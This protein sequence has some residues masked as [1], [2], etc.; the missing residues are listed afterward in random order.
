[1][2]FWALLI[3]S[4]LMVAV[5]TTVIPYISIGGIGPDIIGSFV[6]LVSMLNGRQAG[7]F[8]AVA[9]GL[10]ED[11]S[12][13]QFLGLFT[14]VRLVIA[15]LAGVAHQKVFQEWVLVPMMLVFATGFIGGCFQVFLLVSFGVPFESYRVA[16]GAV[17]FQAVYS[18]LLSPLVMRITCSVDSYVSSCLERRKS[19][20]P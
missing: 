15:Y 14:L 13:G 2:R 4:A 6:A 3:L 9:S 7:F 18:A 19:L 16:L 10:M 17:V 12:S 1:M 11:M 5:E 20:Q 8:V